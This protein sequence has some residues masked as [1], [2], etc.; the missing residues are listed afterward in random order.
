MN[1][2]KLQHKQ[3][4]KRYNIKLTSAFIDILKHVCACIYINKVRHFM[5]K[6]QEEPGEKKILNTHIM[7]CKQCSFM[8]KSIDIF[9]ICNYY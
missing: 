8:C 5:K 4:K 7:C 6:K 2:I 3:C 9:T 1:T